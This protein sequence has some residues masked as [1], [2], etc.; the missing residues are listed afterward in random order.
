MKDVPLETNAADSPDNPLQQYLQVYRN[1]LLNDTL[2][3]WFPRSVDTEYGGFLVCR[4]RDGTVIDTD[5]PVWIQARTVWLLSTL[6]NTVE[7][8]REWLDHASKGIDFIR[9]QAF[10]RDG[11][12]F[13]LLT[14]EGLPLRKRRYLFTEMFVS[15]ALAAYGEAADDKP[16]VQQARDLFRLVLD[17]KENPH[18]LPPKFTATRPAKSLAFPMTLLCTAQILRDTIH[19]PYAED[20]IGSL[21]QE[22]IRDFVKPDSNCVMETVGLHGEF[23]DHFD[24]RMLNPGHAIECA[25]FI[26]QEAKHRGN[27]RRLIETGTA[28]LDWMWSRGWDNEFGGIFYYRDFKGLPVQEYWHDMKFWWP[29][30]E[31]VIATLLA[32]HLTQDPKY[33]H[34]HRLVHDWAYRH[35]PDPEHGEWFGYLHR[36]G[37]VSSTLKGN[38]WKG[39]FHLPRMQLMG[40]RILEE[41]TLLHFG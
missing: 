19:D 34:W 1:G 18:L 24:G 25:W 4:D 29:H 32:Y 33:L 14:R 27:D 11:R 36:D 7:R 15:M 17:Y 12:T 37:R 35:F 2:P 9:R 28:M 10:D 40:W 23:L 3:F 41:I 39:P 30:N 8:R 22:I 16:A 38:H 5:K 21:L 6:Y 31:A 26:L 20:C 13:F